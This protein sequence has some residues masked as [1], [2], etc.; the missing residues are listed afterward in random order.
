VGRWLEEWP[1]G[2]RGQVFLEVG[3]DSHRQLDLPVPDGV[4]LTWLSRN[5]AE[6]GTTS[7]LIDAVRTADWW[8]GRVFA[9]VA[10]E[11]GTLV[12]IRR[13]LRNDRDLPR[14]QM[15]VTGYWRR[16]PVVL[17]ASGDGA[18]DLEATEQQAEKFHELSELLP[19]IAVRVAASIGLA[20]AFD[21]GTRTVS[22]LTAATGAHPVGLK[23]LLRY[24]QAIGI[25]ETAD[26]PGQPSDPRL[27]LTP[28]GREL[29]DED[30]AQAL[31][32]E[33]VLAHRE[34]GGALSLLSAV[35]TGLADSSRGFAAQWARD[36]ATD[37]ALV[38][39]RVREDAVDS[40]YVSGALAASP[41]FD[42][43]S[44]VVVHGRAP[45]GFAHALV[46]AHE[47]LRATVLATAAEL[48]V[49]DDIH[50]PHDRVSSV[51]AGPFG[52]PP[53]PVDAVLLT[54]V[55]AGRGDED[56]VALLAQAAMQVRDRPHGR[57]LLFCEVLDP[58]LAH[59]HDY[60]DDLL[61]FA[62]SGGGMRDEDEHR[63]LFARAGLTV[64][65]RETIGWGHTLH[66]L[67]PHRP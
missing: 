15:E 5:G 8:D 50:S 61:D 4:E 10:G 7:L 43:I 60:E 64:S 42:G 35:R 26:D 23:K 55:L 16:Q 6:A 56:A 2:A 32:L 41:Q 67:V 30:E 11:A 54:D 28:L 46:R 53:A 65:S 59:D 20:E 58:V 37:P 1:T 62:L 48:A 47:G 33:G 49:L 3:E 52:L 21:S 63:E 22:A 14:E 12:P 38:D 9:F 29:E 44:S 45:G 66:A 31:H 40:D 27:V 51:A 39:E 18:V 19:P 34:L 25:V 17:S 24:L 57:V 36:P 13:W